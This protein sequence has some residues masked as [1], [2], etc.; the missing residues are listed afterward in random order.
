[1][2]TPGKP[3]AGETLAGREPSAGDPIGKGEDA[4]GRGEEE[5]YRGRRANRE[6]VCRLD[7]T[8]EGGRAGIRTRQTK[9]HDNESR[10]S[11]IGPKVVRA[12]D[13]QIYAVASQ[14]IN[15]GEETIDHET[16][17]GTHQRGNILKNEYRGMTEA[18]ILEGRFE[19]RDGRENTVLGGE[20]VKV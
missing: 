11:H 9:S 3:G 1:V 15:H 8:P 12:Q 20:P 4:P 7:P 6:G 5:K 18:K 2:H 16:E 13:T 17:S 19:Q 10:P 14:L